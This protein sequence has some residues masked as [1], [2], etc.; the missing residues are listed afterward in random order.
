MKSYPDVTHMQR[1]RKT[2]TINRDSHELNPKTDFEIIQGG[3]SFFQKNIL[4]FQKRFSHI[5]I[6]YFDYIFLYFS[7]YLLNPP[8][9]SC[10]LIC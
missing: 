7:S 2:K 1:T 10:P 4:F 9:N 6:S 5:E 3:F 8:S